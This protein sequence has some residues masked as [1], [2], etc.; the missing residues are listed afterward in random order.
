MEPI[1]LLSATP[2]KLHAI[3]EILFIEVEVHEKIRRFWLMA[4]EAIDYDNESTLF[5]SRMDPSIACRWN[6]EIYDNDTTSVRGCFTVRP[7]MGSGHTIGELLTRLRQI[8]LSGCHKYMSASNNCDNTRILF[9]IMDGRG[10]V[11]GPFPVRVKYMIKSPWSIE[12]P[13]SAA[14]ENPNIFARDYTKLVRKVGCGRRDNY[15]C[16]P[17]VDGDVPRKYKEMVRAYEWYVEG[18]AENVFALIVFHCDG[19]VAIR[20]EIITL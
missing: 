4:P 13:H 14:R 6:G 20:D 12:L 1:H 8:I 3:Y 11:N 15:I 17:Y 18:T 16:V 10:D 2:T 5:M 19:Y 9:W 7:L